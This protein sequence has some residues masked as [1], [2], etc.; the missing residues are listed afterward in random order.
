MD[1]VLAGMD[2]HSYSDLHIGTHAAG[3]EV[4]SMDRHC[5]RKMKP[6]DYLKACLPVLLQWQ[7]LLIVCGIFN[8]HD[9]SGVLFQSSGDN[10]SL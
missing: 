1:H 9:V 10:S 3:S 5:E 4:R 2:T 6:S 8:T 7:I